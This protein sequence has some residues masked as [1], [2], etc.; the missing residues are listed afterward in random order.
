MDLPRILCYPTNQDEW[1][2]I[3]LA[4]GHKPFVSTNIR[5]STPAEVMVHPPQMHINLD[6][7]GMK[8]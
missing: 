1:R 4:K 3:K 7:A 5:I 8:H 2:I 6:D